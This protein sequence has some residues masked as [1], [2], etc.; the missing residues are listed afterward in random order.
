[1]TKSDQGHNTLQMSYKHASNVMDINW[2]NEMKI[3]DRYM[4]YDTASIR[5]SA[6]F[7]T[8]WDNKLEL[9]NRAQEKNWIDF[10]GCTANSF[11]AIPG[12]TKKSQMQEKGHFKDDDQENIEPA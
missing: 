6:E 10:G 7:K 11:W 9:I 1:M 8:M 4:R 3:L 12:H 2:R 5:T